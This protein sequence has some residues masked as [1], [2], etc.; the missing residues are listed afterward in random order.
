MYSKGH[1]GLTLGIVSLLMLPF[2]WNENALIV[3]GIATALSAIPDVDLKWMKHSFSLRDKEYRVK[4]R[5][6]VTH[7]LFFALICGLALG[8]F[9]YF[10]NGQLLW[11]GIGFA[12]PFL[13]VASHL[14]GDTF[15]FHAFQ[16]L[17]PFSDRKYGY[18]FCGASNKA[19]NEGLMT[20]GTILFVL[21]FTVTSGLLK[22]LTAG[23]LG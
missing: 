2:G 23:F 11:F 20:L 16:P 7:S 13:G 14:L 4:H 22:E 9:L 10:G 21:Y 8:S 17:W 18:G 6:K 3:I 12:G 5:G 15:T 1:A 19:A